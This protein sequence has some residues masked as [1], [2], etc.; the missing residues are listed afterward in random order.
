MTTDLWRVRVSVR[1][2]GLSGYLGPATPATPPS[3]YEGG[4]GIG[5]GTL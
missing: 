2:A 4:G 5:Y 1:C 3:T